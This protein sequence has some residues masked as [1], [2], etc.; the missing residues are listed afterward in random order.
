MASKDEGMSN[1]LSLVLEF[2][3]GGLSAW[4][5]KRT[6][7][8]TVTPRPLGYL[9]GS[10]DS[11]S[12]DLKAATDRWPLVFIFELFQV[13]FDRSF[14]SAV[15]NSALATNLFY[16]PFLIRKGKDVPSRW[17]S[18]VAGQP[19]IDPLGLYAFTHHVLVWWCAEQA[20]YAQ[21]DEAEAEGSKPRK[22]PVIHSIQWQPPP[23]GWMK[24][25]TDGCSRGQPGPSSCGG[26]FRNCRGLYM[27][28]LRF[29]W[30][31]DSHIRQSGLGL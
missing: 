4:S 8:T 31:A 11:F 5:K 14:A 19:F 22:A 20:E 16:I 15:V 10:M 17:I 2:E 25:N 1:D 29:R 30:A 23:P 24:V 12:F 21:E 27:D 28:A 3:R 6:F 7:H 9:K 26:I 13:L 18:F